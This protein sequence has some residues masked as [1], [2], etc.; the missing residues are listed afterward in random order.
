MDY[1]IESNSDID[2]SEEV[3]EKD[4]NATLEIETIRMIVMDFDEPYR[5]IITLKH[6]C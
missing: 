5:S 1:Y 4:E 6:L 3:Y 2:L